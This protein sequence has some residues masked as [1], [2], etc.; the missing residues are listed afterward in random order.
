MIVMSNGSL[1][2][3]LVDM[4]DKFEAT[5]LSERWIQCVCQKK[6]MLNKPRAL[7]YFEASKS[8]RDSDILFLILCNKRCYWM[9]VL[10]S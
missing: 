10:H 9:H 2:F 7:K 5:A 6:V 3:V 4:H 1:F 8:S